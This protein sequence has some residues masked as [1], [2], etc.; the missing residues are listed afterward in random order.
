MYVRTGTEEVF[1]A[2]MLNSPTLSGLRDAV[3]NASAK[4]F[5]VED[6]SRWH[7][8]HFLLDSCSLSGCSLQVSEKYGMPKD[9]IG[10]IY[11]KC[12]RG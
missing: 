1:D 5:P 4:P 9:T 3:S 11:K 8:S 12:K 7:F 10:K 2:L 6:F